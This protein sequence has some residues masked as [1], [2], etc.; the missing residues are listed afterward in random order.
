MTT[1]TVIEVERMG[2]EETRVLWNGAELYVMARGISSGGLRFRVYANP[3]HQ[4]PHLNRVYA[5]HAEALAWRWRIASSKRTTPAL[6]PSNPDDFD[7]VP[8]VL[9]LYRGRMGDRVVDQQE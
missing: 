3:N 4:R 2:P 8:R 1:R 6:H 7:T 9:C 5:T